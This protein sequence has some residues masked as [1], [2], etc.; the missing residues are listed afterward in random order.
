MSHFFESVPY[1]SP[2]GPVTVS[3]SIFLSPSV[4]LLAP[5]VVHD[6]SSPVSLKDNTMPPVLN[7]PREKYFRHVYTHLQKVPASELVSAS[8]LVECSPFQPSTPSSD[9]DV[10]IALCEGKQSCTHHLIS[11]FILYDRL[12]LSFR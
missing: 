2:Q 10:P 9:L 5:V 3:K 8:S 4:P 1:F 7:P 11:H 12:T 6:V